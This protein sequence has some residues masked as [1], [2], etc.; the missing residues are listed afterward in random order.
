MRRKYRI[1]LDYE[2]ELDDALMQSFMRGVVHRTVTD[3]QRDEAYDA[4][5]IAPGIRHLDFGLNMSVVSPK[6]R[7][8]R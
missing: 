5:C 1:Q 4:M 3:A 8:K 2:L 7:G 6:R